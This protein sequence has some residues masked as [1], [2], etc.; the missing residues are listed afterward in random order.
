ML[1]V[2]MG[3]KD[4]AERIQLEI[5]SLERLFRAEGPGANDALAPVIFSC[6]PPVRI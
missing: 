4:N 5:A 1:I 3:R 6:V 2:M